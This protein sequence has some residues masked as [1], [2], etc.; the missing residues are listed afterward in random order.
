MPEMACL[1]KVTLGL[2]VLT[3]TTLDP[4]SPVRRGTYNKKVL[5][6]TSKHL[7]FP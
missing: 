3:S 5:N 7:A 2:H 6:L 1:P 4:I